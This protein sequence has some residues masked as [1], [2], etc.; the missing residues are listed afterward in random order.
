M[1]DAHEDM[2]RTVYE[3]VA[4][5]DMETVMGLLTDDIEFHI[6]GRSPVSGRYSGKDEI[7]RFFGKLIETYG[8][9]FQLE[10]QDILVNHKHGVAL[11]RERSQR[12]GKITENR[13]VHVHDIRDGKCAACRAYNED[14]WDEF[15][16]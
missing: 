2:L 13:A 11:T 14:A 5:G 10:V 9:T 15:W 3:S 7:L 1:S 12:G 16:A 6:F 4:K 8:D